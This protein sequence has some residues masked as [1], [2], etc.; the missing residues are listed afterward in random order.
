MTTNQAQD[1]ANNPIKH[2]A[3]SAS[4]GTVQD[5]T[6]Y[7]EQI[8]RAGQHY[9]E[10]VGNYGGYQAGHEYGWDSDLEENH[11]DAPLIKKRSGREAEVEDQLS[12][13]HKRTRSNRSRRELGKR[14]KKQK[15]LRNNSGFFD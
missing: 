3:D 6:L 15:K 2:V 5:R 9:Y 11:L 7:D 4:L 14:K 13:F 8:P 10:T 1:Y 12:G